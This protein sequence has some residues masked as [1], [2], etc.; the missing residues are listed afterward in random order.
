MFLRQWSLEKLVQAENAARV[1]L[2]QLLLIKG[3]ICIGVGLSSKHDNSSG[4]TSC[5]V[6]DVLFVHAN[7]LQ[8]WLPLI[9][10]S[11]HEVDVSAD[12]QRNY[13][14]LTL[15]FLHDIIQ[16][17][18]PL[19]T[20]FVNN[21]RLLNTLLCIWKDITR[22]KMSFPQDL[23]EPIFRTCSDLIFVYLNAFA[24]KPREV[25]DECTPK[26]VESVALTA[27]EFLD[28]IL[29]DFDK[30]GHLVYHGVTIIV[31]L[32]NRKDLNGRHTSI[33]Q[34][35]V[36]K[37][38]EVFWKIVGRPPSPPSTD[39]EKYIQGLH[40]SAIST[41]ITCFCQMVDCYFD[42]V[43]W[44][45]QLIRECVLQA[46]LRCD[47]WLCDAECEEP[48]HLPKFLTQLLPLYLTYRSVLEASQKELIRITQ[49]GLDEHIS[50]PGLKRS[51]TQF[52]A[53]VEVQCTI[54]DQISEEPVYL[55]E[56]CANPRVSLQFDHMIFLLI[57]Y[58]SF[59]SSVLFRLE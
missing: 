40:F 10:K 30:Y 38:S 4:H 32:L 18:H 5:A 49:A 21:P 43:T 13:I 29:S 1:G 26:P 14:K 23:Y 31:H 54:L 45:L 24:S 44:V 12:I 22:N 37:I 53:A 6:C 3:W 16:R 58:T 42:G 8:R 51:W 46:L 35:L 19:Q 47:A 11:L 55:C 20:L 28:E 57:H 25:W 59:I 48:P 56:K 50:N 36:R 7:I 17:K 27:I 33:F 2:D 15:T 9:V 52:K 39:K 41:C 34:R